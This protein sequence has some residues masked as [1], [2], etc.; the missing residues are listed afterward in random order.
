MQ[1]LKLTLTS[2]F[3]II[4]FNL[5]AQQIT[6]GSFGKGILNVVAKDSSFSLKFGARFQGLYTSNWIGENDLEH[7][8]TS[9]LIR[10][11]RLKF[12]GF[13]YSPRLQY[14][15]E[16]GLSNRDISGVSEFTRNTPRI[17][18]D[19]VVKWNFY[20]DFWLWAGQTKLP[21]N[22]ERVIS[23]G[24]LQFVDR[25]LVNSQFNVDR[26]IGFQLRH[27]FRIGD[28]FIV[29][30]A[31]AFSQGEGRNIVTGNLGGHQWTF[32]TEFFPFGEFIKNGAYVGSDIYRE[33]SPKLAVG[34]SYDI[35]N[36]A[37]KTRSNLG[38]YMETDL[39]FF[40]TDIRTLFIDAMF[41]YQG[42]SFM[43]EFSERNS[44]AAIARNIFG[45]P[46]GDI[47]N[48]G[49]GLNLQAGYVFKNNYEIAF[50]YTDIDLE[51]IDSYISEQYTVG[52]SKFIVGHKLKVQTDISYSAF[53]ESPVN[54]LLY[55]LQFD[56]HL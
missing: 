54:E 25:S 28:N 19:A 42:F 12:D 36:D 18:L 8:Q 15:L 43:G 56:L 52:V 20:G 22:R 32:R 4:V 38:S 13:A 10:R 3:F 5:Q 33:K 17:I 16:L 51:E 48:T 24:D 21:G 45:V 40:A 50:R 1:L 6:E 53:N 44:E 30:E 2:L 23:S 35:N 39:G 31:I 11:S 55:R 46:T 37:V 41:K 26:D 14:K 27:K 9:F 29:K 49:K 34:V 47:V 7:D